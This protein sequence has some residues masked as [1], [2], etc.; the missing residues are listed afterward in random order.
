LAIH[1]AFQILQSVPRYQRTI[2]EASIETEDP[3]LWFV[4]QVNFGRLFFAR[5]ILGFRCEVVI[6]MIW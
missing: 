5:Q 3:C 2:V 4:D 1:V 6:V